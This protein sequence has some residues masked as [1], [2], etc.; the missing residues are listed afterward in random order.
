[1]HTTSMQHQPSLFAVPVAS[2][3]PSSPVAPCVISDARA[4][5]VF[6]TMCL[7]GDTAASR[8]AP[9]FLE[10]WQ[11]GYTFEALCNGWRPLSYMALVEQLENMLDHEQLARDNRLSHAQGVSP[12]SYTNMLG[13][14]YGWL[15]SQHDHDCLPHVPS[16]VFP[17][18][19]TLYEQ[20]HA[21]V[22]RLH[23]ARL[24]D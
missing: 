21:L 18:W 4:H 15:L 24:T 7:H 1:M 23:V 13:F 11:E 6:Q 16:S 22:G 17:T 3:S 5:A 20:M 12:L 9:D 2:V 8:N 19:H 14:A 10:G